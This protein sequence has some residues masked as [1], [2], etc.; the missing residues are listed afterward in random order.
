MSPRRWQLRIQDMIDAAKEIQSFVEGMDFE[1]F[2][3]DIKTIRAVEL[4]FIIV[5]E[6]A[7]LIPQEIQDAHPEI[8]WHFIRGMRNRLV[9][10]YFEV[11]PKL[12]W[13]TIQND[14]SLL[15]SALEKLIG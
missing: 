13:D 11:D 4:N 2:K 5:G 7:A 9:H 14:L 12:V 15:I 8:P 3:D 10:T 6:A 1:F